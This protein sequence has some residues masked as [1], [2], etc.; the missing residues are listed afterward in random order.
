[1]ARGYIEISD[2]ETGIIFRFYDDR[3][4]P[5][6]LHIEARWHTNPSDA[7]QAFADGIEHTIWLEGKRCFESIGATHSVVWLWMDETRS[8]VLVI[9]CVP[10]LARE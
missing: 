4:D 6:R 9:T 1:M 10:H 3:S 2:L 5:T 7:I 8:R